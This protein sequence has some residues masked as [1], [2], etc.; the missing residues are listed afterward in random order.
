MPN[1]S[2]FEPGTRRH[3]NSAFTLIELLVVIAIIAILAA[4]L[5]PVFA[6]A[7]DKARQTACASNMK[8]INLATL[9]YIQDF[10]E[11]WPITRPI[12]GGANS[13]ANNL[14]STPLFSASDTLPAPSDA[15]RSMYANAL[16]PYI[17][18]WDV[19]ACP[20]G[21]DYNVFKEAETALGQA[22]FSYALNG[23]LNVWADAQTP[24][25]TDTVSYM[26]IPKD[27]RVRKY[28]VP[29][30][31]PT[32]NCSGTDSVPY[33]FSTNSGCFDFWDSYQSKYWI[34]GEGGNYAYMDG[35]VKWV[36]NPSDR[37]A[38]KQTLDNSNTTVANLYFGAGIW[39]RP[40][41]PVAK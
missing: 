18:S 11:I 1:R 29:F 25:P 7:R 14:S 16:H 12:I 8:Q 20:S 22:R 5:F 9:Q 41:A 4:I 15:A 24:Q 23:Y 27:R 37:S 6:N 35:H 21:E 19:W 34:H 3:T 39:L 33:Q 40:H 26:E 36:R 30:P 10:D 31:F 28:I 32:Q 17:K 2:R 13:A 38:W